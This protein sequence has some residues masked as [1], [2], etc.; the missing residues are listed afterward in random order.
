MYTY[1]PSHLRTLK[2]E[3]FTLED[4][5]QRESQAMR[6]STQISES[7]QRCAKMSLKSMEKNT[8]LKKSGVYKLII[9][10]SPSVCNHTIIIY[11]PNIQQS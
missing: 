7:I 6:V 9:Y 2:W 4:F 11:N 10:R 8:W 1:F 5:L 3:H